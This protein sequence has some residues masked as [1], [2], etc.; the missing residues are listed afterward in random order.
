VTFVVLRDFAETDDKQRRALR[1]S[2]EHRG[3]GAKLEQKAH[4]GHRGIVA[5]DGVVE[6][7]GVLARG[8]ERIDVALHDGVELD[9]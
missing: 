2:A 6:R 5:I 4:N 7:R 8:V 9:A 3:R 1:R